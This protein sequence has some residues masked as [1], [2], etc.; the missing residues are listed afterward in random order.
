[1]EIDGITVCT[2]IEKLVALLERHSYV[3]TKRYVSDC[4]FHEVAIEMDG[5]PFE[6]RD[7]IQIAGINR[8]NPHLFACNCHWS[9]LKLNCKRRTVCFRLAQ[10]RKARFPLK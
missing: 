10:L 6:G 1:M 7:A 2:P 3:V 5:T 9:T 8:V 4:H